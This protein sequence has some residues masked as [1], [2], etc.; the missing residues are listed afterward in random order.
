MVTSPLCSAEAAPDESATEPL[1]APS[2]E[3]AITVPPAI[4]R[5]R[6]YFLQCCLVMSSTFNA[7]FVFVDEVDVEEEDVKV[8]LDAERAHGGLKSCI[9]ADSDLEPT[10][11]IPES[12]TKTILVG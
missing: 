12:T 1:S 3:P 6:R 7:I 4:P 10:C 2:A 11:L 8:K 5:S 9:S